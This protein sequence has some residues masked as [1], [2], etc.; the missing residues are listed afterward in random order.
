MH[1]PILK[2][3]NRYK[4]SIISFGGLN[5]TSDYAEGEL[6]ECNGITHGEYPFLT[7]RKKRE[8][9]FRCA[10][11][12][13][14]IFEKKECI[15]AEDGLYYDRKKVGELSPGKKQIAVLGSKILVFPDKMYYDT[16]KNEFKHLSGE[17]YTSGTVTFTTNSISL[18]DG[19]YEE[20]RQ[21][22]KTEFQKD[23]SLVTYRE[24]AVS[25]RKI[26]FSGFLPK[27]PGEL[28]AET[29]IFE[30]C[31]QN[32]YRVVTSV[33][34]NE[35]TD[36][37]EIINEL[38]TIKNYTGNLFSH[39]KVGDVVEISGCKNKVYNNKSATVVSNRG[40]S[41][42][43]SE[44]TFLEVNEDESITIKRKIPD[45]VSVCTYE[46]RLWGCEGN[47]IY[48]SALGDATSFFTYQGIST[49]S[50]SVKSNSAGDFTACVN[51]G[52]SCYFFKETSCYRLYGN[53][54]A[55]FQLT[56]SFG[57]GILKSDAK[58]IV[59][60]GDRLIYKG[61]GGIY[62]FYGGSPT[63]ISDK[64]GN[65]KMRNA[66]A[67]TDG[68]LYY[69]SADTENGREEFIWDIEKN[70]WCKS[71]I[72]GVN[73]YAS[74]GENV[75]TFKDEGIEKISEST[76]DKVLWSVTL[77]P[78]DEKY[79]KTKNYSRLH[80]KTQLF[81]GSF[82]SVDIKY[83]DSKWENI[84]SFHGES[85]RYLNIPC[86]VKKCHEFSIRISGKGKSVL[87][88]IVREYTVN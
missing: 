31:N 20:I 80:L 56:E 52:N 1:L 58:S 8:N 26:T 74:Y 19:Y 47:T 3:E 39:F 28:S 66:T 44:G 55:N 79:Y 54:P 85:K 6:I 18:K 63:R 4:R 38:V 50:F 30:K 69:I 24:V 64:L 34:Y 17:V 41:L 14:V 25:N 84:G 68:K 37:Y 53:R 87:E 72:K 78:F 16:E 86:V 62:S 43:F 71:G 45:F 7:Q 15:A 70:F 22:E 11:P 48:A 13:A 42:I 65:I 57:A 77:C 12:S 60:A 27:L 73:G 46:N 36:C 49:D 2:R 33:N 81:K 61:N 75:F 76:D 59:T 9:E 51:Y 5:L 88:S 29:I 10:Y 35:E 67:G 40:T 21:M 83:D 32:Q 82:I 23:I